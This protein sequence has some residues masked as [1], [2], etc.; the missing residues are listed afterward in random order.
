VRP[1]GPQGAARELGEKWGIEGV[2]SGGV[3]SEG[4]GDFKLRGFDRI[5]IG[6]EGEI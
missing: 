4:V 2:R 3:G 6:R 1:K 5:E